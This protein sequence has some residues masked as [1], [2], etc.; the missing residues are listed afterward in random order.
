MEMNKMQKSAKGFRT[1]FNI[2]CVFSIACSILILFVFIL[3]AAGVVD[4]EAISLNGTGTPLLQ[5]ADICFPLKDMNGVV[6]SFTKQQAL[7]LLG[8]FLPVFAIIAVEFAFA[9][10]ILQ[11]VCEGKPFALSVSKNIRNIGIAVLIDGILTDVLHGISS[12]IL[13][14]SIDFTQLLN[15]NI[16]DKPYLN[17]NLT[18]TPKYF[19]A[20]LIILLLARV[21]RY[22]AEL[23]QESDETL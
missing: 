6:S 23:Q 19:V 17:I 22:G 1:F 9:A 14:K 15:T 3:I 2:L 11:S 16:V 18:A 5:L 12:V 13:F 8:S 21:F 20:F 7:I 10:R 4:P